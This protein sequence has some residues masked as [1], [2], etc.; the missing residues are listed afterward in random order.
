MKTKPL[1]LK[2]ASGGERNSVRRS[3]IDGLARI[4]ILPKEEFLCFINPDAIALNPFATLRIGSKM[5]SEPERY[6]RPVYFYPPDEEKYKGKDKP[7]L[8]GQN[9]RTEYFYGYVREDEIHLLPT[10]H[11][12][13]IGN[14][15]ERSGVTLVEIFVLDFKGHVSKKEPMDPEKRKEMLQTRSKNYKPN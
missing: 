7:V 8:P 2:P 9:H 5:E 10:V 1:I 11:K 12:F 14:K 3:Y 6:C 4:Q 15:I 13:R